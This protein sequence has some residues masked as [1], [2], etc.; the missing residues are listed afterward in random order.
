MFIG[1]VPHSRGLR[2]AVPLVAVEGVALVLYGVFILVQSLRLGI[3]GPAVEVLLYHH[4]PLPFCT[5][6][7]ILGIER[8][9]SSAFL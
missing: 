8:S 4:A 3:T 1:P 2:I 7:G 5:S 6:G 9:G